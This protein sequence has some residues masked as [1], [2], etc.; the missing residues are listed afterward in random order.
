MSRCFIIQGIVKKVAPD[1]ITDCMIKLKSFN[2]SGIS[3]DDIKILNHSLD[4]I[5]FVLENFVYVK[6]RESHNS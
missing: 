5:T 1:E 2:K 6:F 3:I 4:L